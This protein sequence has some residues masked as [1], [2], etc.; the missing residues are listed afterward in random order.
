MQAER[1]NSDRAGTRFPPPQAPKSTPAL[2][3][4]S[5]REPSLIGRLTTVAHPCKTAKKKLLSDAET[6]VATTAGVRGVEPPKRMS[7]RRTWKVR[8]ARLWLV[9]AARLRKVCAG[10][11]SV[12]VA[13][14]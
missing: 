4:F 10:R 3:K 6:T 13:R 14:W 2:T 9:R 7:A 11:W 8:A 1:Q 12:R 5:R